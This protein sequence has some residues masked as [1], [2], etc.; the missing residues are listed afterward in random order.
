MAVPAPRKQRAITSDRV[1]PGKPASI[2]INRF[3][4]LSRFCELTGYATST[5]HGWT[6]SGHIP[7]RRGER[8]Y[9]AH[10]LSVAAK[11]KI[12]LDP[13]DFVEKPAALGRGR[14]SPDSA[15]PPLESADSAAAAIASGDGLPPP[16]AAAP[17]PAEAGADGQ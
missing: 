14:R 8:A 16:A 2:V 10:I 1:D 9:H 11:H 17:L 13:S 4:G 15:S 3:G 5:A 7:A 6:V 12:P